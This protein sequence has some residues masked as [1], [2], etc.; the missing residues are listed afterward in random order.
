MPSL[1]QALSE[2]NIAHPPKWLPKNVMF[3]CRM[4]SFAYGC[5]TQTSDCD[6][7]G[8]CIPPKE[9]VFRIGEIPGFD[10]KQNRFEQYCEPHLFDENEKE[11]D[12]TCYSIVKYFSLCMGCNPNMIDS[13]FVPRECITHTTQLG[14]MVRERRHIFLSKNIK[15]KFL[16]YAYSQFNKMSSK[17]PEKGSK[18]SKIREEFGFDC[19]YAMHLVRLVLECEQALT[20]GDIDLRRNSE[21]LKSIRNG[22]WSEEKVKEWFSEKEKY[23]EK[24]YDENNTLPFKNDEKQIKSLLLDCLEHHYGNL[25]NVYEEPDAILKAI[26]QI[27]EISS[28]FVNNV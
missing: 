23:M 26:K 2:K 21:I 27:N 1:I 16:G 17:N 24:I 10:D 20:E 22:E 5:N 8:F 11:F 12:L 9:E 6:I 13:L 28:K 25:K 19:K 7:Y 18:R 3:E 4:G 15:N 14:E